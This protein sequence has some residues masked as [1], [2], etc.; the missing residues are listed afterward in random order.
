MR[1]DWEESWRNAD[2]GKNPHS[3]AQYKWSKI[4]L[5]SPREDR[6]FILYSVE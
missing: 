3:D 5:E 6:R 1:S 2:L 4:T